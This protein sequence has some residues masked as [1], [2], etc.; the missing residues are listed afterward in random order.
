M[1]HFTRFSNVFRGVRYVLW[2][3]DDF[4]TSATS[5]EPNSAHSAKVRICGDFGHFR[6]FLALYPLPALH[7]PNG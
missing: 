3:L 1:A 7:T 4:L 5:L 2:V 6:V